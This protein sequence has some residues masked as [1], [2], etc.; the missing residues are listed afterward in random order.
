MGSV[1]SHYAIIGWNFVLNPIQGIGA[2]SFGLRRLTAAVTRSAY[3][4]VTTPD[5]ALTIDDST[6]AV[7]GDG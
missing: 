2:M 3:H 1:S 6:L 7:D 5:E 4:A